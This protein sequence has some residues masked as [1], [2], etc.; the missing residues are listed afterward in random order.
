MYD[1]RYHHTAWETAPSIKQA[2]A[3]IRREFGV[4]RVFKIR[5]E[6][7]IYCYR[8]RKE[9]MDDD[10]GESADAVICKPE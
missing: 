5:C 7:G 3:Q 1:I 9:L 10:T 8:S 6:D 4:A 2:I